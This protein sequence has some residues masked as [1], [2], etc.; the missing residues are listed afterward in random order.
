[1]WE[2]QNCRE[3]IEDRYKH[4]WNC[5]RPKPDD[6]PVP[7][8]VKVQQVVNPTKA[9]TR[10]ESTP[11]KPVN[12]PPPESA[13]EPPPESVSAPPP[14]A[15][16]PPTAGAASEKVTRRREKITFED[17]VPFEETS[18]FK[19]EKT[20]EDERPF[21][22]KSPSKLGQIA[23][24]VLWLAAVLA[25]SCFAYYSYQKTKGFENRIAEDARNLSALT[26]QFAFSPSAPREKNGAIKAKILPL[27]A[28]N[29][30]L[31][32]LYHA[33]PDDLRPATLEEV[34]TL[35]WLDC[36]LKEVWRYDDGSPGFRQTCNAYLIDRN[37]SKRIGLEEFPGEMPPLKKEPGSEPVPGKVAP[38]AYI[39]FIR[40]HQPENERT[41]LASASD[42]PE[43]HYLF[44]SELV[45]ALI[46]L[47]LLC[48]AGV[49]WLVYQIKSA[50]WKP[51]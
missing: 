24:L 38:A 21:A 2:C 17:G 7:W 36:G 37:T 4:C 44:K 5:G 12:E 20:F 30:R 42:S 33:L 34:N 6:R 29:R 46:L 13:S 26:N 35:L 9:E 49:G 3:K 18:S 39:A 28:K 19:E 23:P 32:D 25:V 1:M 43:H 41:A 22:E 40:Q 16:A 45:Y 48:A 10:S 27:D 47:A 15:E 11:P 31:D 8:S 51:E 50:L 14:P